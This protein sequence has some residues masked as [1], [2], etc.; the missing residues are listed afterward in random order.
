[1]TRE[2]AK[3]QVRAQLTGANLADELISERRTDAAADCR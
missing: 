1:M 2:Q 3:T